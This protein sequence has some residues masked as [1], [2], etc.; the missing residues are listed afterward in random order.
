ML[1]SDFPHNCIDRIWRASPRCVFSCGFV[2]YA[3]RMLSNCNC[4]ICD[5]FHPS[6]NY[7]LSVNFLLCGTF[8]QFFSLTQMPIL[9]GHLQQRKS[10]GLQP[11]QC[12]FVLLTWATNYD[13]AICFYFTSN[14]N[15]ILSEN[16]QSQ[17]FNQKVIAVSFIIWLLLFCTCSLLFA[18]PWLLFLLLFSVATWSMLCIAMHTSHATNKQTNK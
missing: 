18:G 10:M 5:T 14:V 17:N 6:G 2:S 9:F 4:Y 7:S 12:F 1:L 16:F 13:W 8:L 11:S 3:D 15:W